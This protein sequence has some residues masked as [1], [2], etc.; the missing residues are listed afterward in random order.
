[1]SEEE[2]ILPI[3][4]STIE[5]DELILFAIGGDW[6]QDP[7]LNDTDFALVYCI[8]G[9][10]IRNW[11]ENKGQSAS[12]RK[13]KTTS[14]EKRQLIDGD[15]LVEISGGGPE[16]P[17]GRT[18]L[19]EKSTLLFKP[20]T[21]KICTNFLRLIRPSKNFNSYF[22]NTFLK[23][24]YN[25]GKI[26][27]YQAGSNNLRNLKFNHYIK[28]KIPIP[29]LQEQHRIVA[30]I[31][32]L[33]SDLDQGIASLKKVQSQLKTYRQAVLKDAFEGKL[34]AQWREEHAS[35]LETAEDVLQ[36]IKSEREKLVREALDQWEADVK[37]WELAGKVAGKPTKPSHKF[38]ES[39]PITDEELETLFELPPSWGWEKIGNIF[40]VYVGS[41]P[42]RKV[43]S[44]WNGDINWV[45]S[46][47]VAFCNIYSTKEKI[48]KLGLNNSSTTVHPSGTVLL[49]MIGEGKTRGQAAIIKTS[50]AHN[51]NT[52]ALRCISGVCSPKYLFY[53]FTF[54]YE[55]TRRIGS[56]NSQKALNKNMIENM[57]FPLCFY[58][59]QT[60]IVS[61][62]ESRLSICDKL[63]EMVAE[64][65]KKADL[66]RQSILK[67]AFEGKL[68]PQDPN[69]EPASILLERI[70]AE[71][72]AYLTAE[73]NEKKST[74]KRS[75]T[76]MSE[77]KK[78]VIEILK[79]AQGPIPA[80]EVWKNSVHAD[81]IDAFYA[82]VKNLKGQIKQD[83]QALETFLS[84]KS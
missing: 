24:F 39:E 37:D 54:S 33:F 75:Q 51:Q 36:K 27:N 52:A 45:S 10:E 83:K 20:N 35:E 77:K 5:L 19:I 47:E 61:E 68:V 57:S 32:E 43:S 14:I 8:R 78:Q 60:Q 18:V 38:R 40:S 73:K 50:A 1:M 23:Y 65:L 53:F 30:K 67:Q 4:W 62:I 72:A 71:K 41:T 22:L 11:N 31:E 69:D 74:P 16:Q 44:Y 21:P 28:I 84:L 46:G 58:Q 15:I 70:K 82:T 2:V 6:G 34:T 17:V 29:P 63:E 3:N 12:L 9:A 80:K 81:D 26:I 49:G 55:L 25:S 42:S 7:N 76:K 66:M 64:N 59:E 48:T 79:A 56:G 13:V